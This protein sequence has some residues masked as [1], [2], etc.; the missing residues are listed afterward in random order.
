MNFVFNCVVYLFMYILLVSGGGAITQ[1]ANMI[2]QND[3]KAGSYSVLAMLWSFL[4]L[5]MIVVLVR[6]VLN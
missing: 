6:T 2:E 3:P 5:F 1:A 4:A